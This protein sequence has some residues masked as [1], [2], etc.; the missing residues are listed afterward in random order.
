[1]AN[2]NKQCIIDKMNKGMSNTEAT[3]QCAPKQSGLVANGE[4]TQA[5][6]DKYIKPQ[7]L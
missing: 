6:V 1:M 3:K 7:I 5:E 4:M 2:I